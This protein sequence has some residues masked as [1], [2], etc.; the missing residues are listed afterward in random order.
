MKKE[1]PAGFPE[2]RAVCRGAGLEIAPRNPV[3]TGAKPRESSIDVDISRRPMIER[4]APVLEAPLSIWCFWH[5]S[6]TAQPTSWLFAALATIL[7]I[8]FL[9]DVIRF[10]GWKLQMSPQE[11]R[12]RRN[13]RWTAIPW[14]EI[15]A[16]HT[17][18]AGGRNQEAVTLTLAANATL[19]L[20][21]FSYPFALALRD[22]LRDEITSQ[23]AG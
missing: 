2:V 18:P 21:T 12:V 5:S 9:R 15:Q 14:R 4:V 11:M 23:S 1:T 13:Y 17:V 10:W 22:R 20:G 3:A 16:V 19:S 6:A 8:L 7:L